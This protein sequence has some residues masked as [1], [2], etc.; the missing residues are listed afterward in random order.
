M[1]FKHLFT[2]FLDKYDNQYGFRH[3]NEYDDNEYDDNKLYQNKLVN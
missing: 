2:S 3:D 1:F